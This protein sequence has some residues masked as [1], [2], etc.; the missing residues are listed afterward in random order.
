MNTLANHGYIARNGYASV[1][2]LTLASNT[3][4]GMGHDLAAFLSVYSGIMSGDLT[5]VSIGGPAPGG[6]L[7]G[8]SSTLGL[9]GKPQGLSRSHGRFET[10]AS[11]LRADLYTS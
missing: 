5:S 10:D 8:L 9:I 4:F 1:V 7:S 6:L 3:V 2:D 11:P